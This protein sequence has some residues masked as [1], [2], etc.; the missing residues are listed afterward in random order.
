MLGIYS[1]GGGRKGKCVREEISGYNKERKV[2]EEVMLEREE[3]YGGEES[4]YKMK[5]RLRKE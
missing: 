4:K 5:R 1:A 3:A 2:G